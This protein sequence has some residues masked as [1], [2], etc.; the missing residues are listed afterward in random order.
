MQAIDFLRR[1]LGFAR[2]AILKLFLRERLSF[3]PIQNASPFFRLYV[4]KKA[5]VVLGRNITISCGVD[6]C[7]VGTGK[8]AI[9]S[10]VYLGPRCMLSAHT[11]IS[12]GRDTL[13]GPDVKIFDNNHAFAAGIG[14]VHGQHKFAAVKIGSNCWVGANV[15]ILKGVTVGE[16]SVIGAGCVVR[17]DIPPFSITTLGCGLSTSAI[18]SENRR[19]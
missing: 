7:A 14:V 17:K 9:E 15:V 1:S 6:I 11:G 3:N 5:R 8:I 4:D 2:L 10:R 16:G 18:G 12:I 13:L 19:R